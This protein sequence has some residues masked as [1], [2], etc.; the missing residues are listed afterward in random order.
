MAVG[1]S[2][3]SMSD[4]ANAFKDADHA[5]DRLSLTTPYSF[6]DYRGIRLNDSS[7]IPSSGAVSIDDF[8]GHSPYVPWSNQAK[9]DDGEAN[10]DQLGK[11][12]SI[13]GDGKTG[14]AG[15]VNHDGAKGAIYVYDFT[16][17]VAPTKL[18]ASD[19]QSNDEFG[20]SVA[21]SND[22]N[23]IAV[24]APFSDY[25]SYNNAGAVYIFT[26]S[27]GSWS[28]QDKLVTSDAYTNSFFGMSVAI[29]HNGNLVVAGAPGDLTYAGSAYVFTRSGSTWS[30][31]QKLGVGGTVA[32]VGYDEAGSSVSV[33]GDGLHIMVGAKYEDTTATNAGSIYYWTRP[34][35]GANAT[36]RQRFQHSDA[37]QY[38]NAGK[39]NSIEISGDGN[40]FVM[41]VE[42]ERTNADQN[43]VNSRGAAY[44]FTR[45][46]NTW[47]QR[48]RFLAYDGASWDYFGCSVSISNA[49]DRVIVGAQGEDGSSVWDSGSVYM[50]IRGSNNWQIA[51]V[52]TPSFRAS[53]AAQ[54]DYLGGDI[55]L[56][57]NGYRFLVGA[58][59][60]DHSNGTNRGSVY[61]FE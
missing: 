14:V 48:K 16:D 59:S 41:G 43:T 5:R 61:T 3:V 36:M 40:T 50:Y 29:S 44:L 27:N 53:D 23:T 49:G 56:S 12:V 46:G 54:N 18:Q 33:S 39:L 42:M 57:G 28:Q 6:S 60:T 52:Y 20:Y 35:S 26:K 21:I 22:G 31:E 24:G 58:N 10:Y 47:T 37:S 9:Y 13:S 55:S 17:W 8:R 4:I 25:Y 15:S 45:S 34:S 19:K 38:D 1:T 7:F 30:Q 11:S 32:E 51:F 2:D